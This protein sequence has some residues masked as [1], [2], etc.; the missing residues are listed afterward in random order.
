MKRP[1]SKIVSNQLTFIAC[2]VIVV[3]YLVQAY[4]AIPTDE[5]HQFHTWLSENRDRVLEDPGST[6]IHFSVRVTNENNTMEW[7]VSDSDDD[8]EHNRKLIRL[9]ELAAT[10]QLFLFED[11]TTGAAS[12]VT[13]NLD[14]KSFSAAVSRQRLESTPSLQTLLRLSKVYSLSIPDSNKEVA[15]ANP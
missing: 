1:P 14:G 4:Q 8:P 12:E 3:V 10:S 15:H 6:N 11:N 5:Q 9:L 2:T 13:I 7:S